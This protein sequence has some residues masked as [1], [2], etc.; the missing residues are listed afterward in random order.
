VT[1]PATDRRCG[2]CKWWVRDA[3]PIIQPAYI[4]WGDCEWPKAHRPASLP[5]DAVEMDENEGTD[6]SQWSDGAEALG[7]TDGE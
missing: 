1:S 5:T 4:A 3:N 2:T 7:E 6:C